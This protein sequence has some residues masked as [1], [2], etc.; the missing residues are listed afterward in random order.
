[1][2]TKIYGKQKAQVELQAIMQDVMI[3]GLLLLVRVL[4]F[5][6][7]MSSSNSEKNKP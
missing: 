4:T 2:Q 3:I 5:Q 1:M 6:H 7:Y